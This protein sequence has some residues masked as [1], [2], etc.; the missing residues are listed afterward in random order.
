MP[1]VKR[2]YAIRGGVV[3][4]ADEYTAEIDRDFDFKIAGVNHFTWLLKAEYKGEDV[5][6]VIAETLR[7]KAA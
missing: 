2:N 1:M 3:N 5:T 7:E 6:T 4:S